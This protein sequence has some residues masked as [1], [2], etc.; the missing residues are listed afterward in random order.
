M[1]PEL[2]PVGQVASLTAIGI[3]I[4]AERTLAGVA[5]ASAVNTVRHFLG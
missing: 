2:G 5:E 3:L 4:I 1:S